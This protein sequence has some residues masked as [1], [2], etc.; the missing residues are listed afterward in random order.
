L[1]TPQQVLRPVAADAERTRAVLAERLV[2]HLRSRA[3]AG[4][5][6]VKG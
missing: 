4:S 2:K 1:D 5:A 6:S 3:K